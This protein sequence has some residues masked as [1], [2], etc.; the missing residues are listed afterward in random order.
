MHMYLLLTHILEI[1]QQNQD[2]KPPTL[3]T[4][5]NH[6]QIMH[7]WHTH[8]FTHAHMHVQS[9]PTHIHVQSEL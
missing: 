8:T 1:L 6:I 4:L 7:A 5:I 9:E 2:T 3:E